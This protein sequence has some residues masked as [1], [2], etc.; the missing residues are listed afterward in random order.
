MITPGGTVSFDIPVM[1]T[2]RYG[3]EEI[4]EKNLLFLIP[5]YIFSHESRFEEYNND[6]DK[7]EIL[8]AEYADIMA[9]L[10]QLLEKGRSEVSYGRKGS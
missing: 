7:L 5:F 8:K 4:F 1:K 6:K 2:Q 3:I 9:R 10:D